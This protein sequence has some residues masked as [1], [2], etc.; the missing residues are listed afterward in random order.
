MGPSSI[1]VVNLPLDMLQTGAGTPIPWAAF[2]VHASV[3][4]PVVMTAPVSFDVPGMS[5]YQYR[6]FVLYSQ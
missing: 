1:Q 3:L 5:E 4:P 2:R 6:T